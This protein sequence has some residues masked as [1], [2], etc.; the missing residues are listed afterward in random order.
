[1]ATLGQELKQRR[2]K[3]GFS[4]KDISVQS[5]VSVRMLQALEEDRWDILR[6][7]FFI[8]GVLRSY[9][10]AI[11]EDEAYFFG[12]LAEELKPRAAEPEKEPRK[13]ENS[14]LA[15][16]RLSRDAFRRPNA[17]RWAILIVLAALAL[18]VFLYVKTRP[19]QAPDLHRPAAAAPTIK[20]PAAPPEEK[21]K[22]EAAAETAPLMLDFSFKADTWIRVEADGARVL[23]QTMSPGRT[24]SFR[25]KNDFL[26][27][28][29]NAG[30]FTYTLNGKPGRPLG[31]L[32][33]VLTDI[34]ITPQNVA[35]FQQTPSGSGPGR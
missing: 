4:L 13:R 16:H 9:V 6:E 21:P 32:G 17:G 19:R 27:Q 33:A 24:M 23:E 31:P 34:R 26:V 14:A 7:P 3:R 11:G 22:T 8:K 20:A 18:A 12:R 10:R 2:D 5:K 15:P 25:A 35:E 29:G 30:G 1:M 28:I